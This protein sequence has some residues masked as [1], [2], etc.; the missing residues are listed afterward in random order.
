MNSK[1]SIAPG[2]V[3]LLIITMTS[4]TKSAGIATFVNFSIPLDTPRST[5][6]IVSAMNTTV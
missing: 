5:I 2:S 4:I 3:T 6:R 1:P